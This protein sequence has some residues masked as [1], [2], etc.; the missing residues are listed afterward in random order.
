M[1]E[2]FGRERYYA[3]GFSARAFLNLERSTGELVDRAQIVDEYREVI[4]QARTTLGLASTTR[5]VLTGWSRGAAFAILAGG[6]DRLQPELAGVIAIGLPDEEQLRVRSSSD[7]K[8]AD[9]QARKTAHRLQFNT[10]SVIPALDDLPCAVIQSTHDDYLPS[11]AARLLFGPDTALRRLYAVDS[12]NHRFS[13]GHAQFI[14]SLGD[15]LRWVVTHG[16]STT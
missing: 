1:F 11:A 8:Q 16:R 12:R 5:T 4:A 7:E 14:T 6:D 2:Q 9:G 13:G 10:Y 3:A 15:A